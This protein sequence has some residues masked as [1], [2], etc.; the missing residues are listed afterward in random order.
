MYLRIFRKS[1]ET[2]QVSSKSHKRKCTLH[3]DLSALMLIS[4]SIRHR[5]IIFSDILCRENPNVPYMFNTIPSKIVQSWGNVI[6][7]GTAGQVTDDNKE[8]AHCI[9]DKA[10][11]THSEYVTFIAFPL[12]QWLQECVSMLRYPYISCLVNVYKFDFNTSD[13]QSSKSP[14]K[15][16]FDGLLQKTFHFS[17][18]RTSICYTRWRLCK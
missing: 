9:L 12:Q 16:P 17:L 14:C 15:F 6:K 3:E 13:F 5:M 8:R 10:T 1:V 2:I 18:F 7:Y 11:N 4:L